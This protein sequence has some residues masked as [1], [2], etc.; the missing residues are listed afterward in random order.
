V[1][2]H[3]NDLEEVKKKWDGE[4]E[5][6]SISGLA[7]DP[8]ATCHH[9]N[10]Q[11]VCTAEAMAEDGAWIHEHVQGFHSFQDGGGRTQNT[12]ISLRRS[13]LLHMMN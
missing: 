4:E 3:K 11:D 9:G 2:R 1:H 5:H 13:R 12:P 10:D 6:I 8:S 7:E